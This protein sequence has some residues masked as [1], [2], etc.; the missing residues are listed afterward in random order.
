MASCQIDDANT[1]TEQIVARILI[2]YKHIV[3][4]V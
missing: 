1:L 4:L 3:L 2:Q